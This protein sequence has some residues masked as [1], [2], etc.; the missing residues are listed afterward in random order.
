[1]LPGRANWLQ[2]RCTG[3]ALA[4]GGSETQ[5][6]RVARQEPQRVF[7]R[8]D[9]RQRIRERR[10]ATAGQAQH[11]L[12]AAKGFGIE[13]GQARGFAGIAGVRGGGSAAALLVRLGQAQARGVEQSAQRL[14]RRRLVGPGHAAQ[15][16]ARCIGRGGR[17]WRAGWL[18]RRPGQGPR[19]RG[20]PGIGAAVGREQGR[21]QA[22]AGQ[23]P[24]PPAQPGRRGMALELGAPAGQQ[25]AAVFD[26]GRAGPLA[27]AAAQA[28]VQ[29]QVAQGSRGQVPRRHRLHIGYAAPRGLGFGGV[30]AV[31]GAVRQA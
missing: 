12:A 29:V 30:Q 8:G 1:M 15:E 18:R 14:A 13:P 16:Q 2:G 7:H 4:V 28:V 25:Q 22:R 20:Q 26:A 9:A 24:E 23:Q 31:G 11:A 5:P 3:D 17:P 10:L 27:A 6:I 19:T 21:Q